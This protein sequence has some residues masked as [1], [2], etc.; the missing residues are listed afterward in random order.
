MRKLHPD[1]YSVV[2]GQFYG[3]P[4]ELWGFRSG[5]ASG[6]ARRIAWDFLATHSQL[7]GLD[8]GL[9]G[10]RWRRTITSLGAEHVIFEQV[11]EQLRIHRAY[12]T[13]HVGRS[14]RRVFLTKNRAV[15]KALLPPRPERKVTRA[16]AV[17]RALRSVGT[18]ASGA[19]VLGSEQVWCP[20]EDEL[21]L[22]W[23]IRL[24]RSRPREEWIHYVD[25]L[26]G[27]ILSEYDNLAGA[28][29]RAWVFDPNPVVTLDGT[30]EL[31]TV[32][33]NPRRR[34]PDEAFYV[35]DL[36]GLDESGHLDG[37]RATTKP[38][39]RRV[40][41]RSLDFRFDAREKGFEEVMAYYHVDRAIRY[42]ESLGFRGRSA[43]FREPLRIRA[44]GTRQDNSWYSPGLRQLTF[45]SGGVDDAEDAETILHEFGH[46]LQDAIT[47]DF[48]QSEEAAAMG[49]GF[50]DYFAA[51][52][53]SEAKSPRYRATVMSWDGVTWERDDGPPCVR[54]VDMSWTMD[55]W[56][57]GDS[58]H[59]NGEIWSST[60]WD[61][62]GALGRELADR[63]I[64]ESHFQLDPFSTMA[65]G[66]RA[67]LDADA[68]LERGRNRGTLRRIF[69]AHRVGPI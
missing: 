62:R 22:S 32:A 67:I 66:A 11:H 1:E 21:R 59:A 35:V 20:R 39:T 60:L 40:R 3:T 52:F 34:I 2:E 26:S 23:K 17:R 48:G 8:S 54:R 41:R 44:N 46:A 68:N 69:R 10:L 50:G 9:E 57:E 6:S 49:E 12:V 36:R 31:L 19:R 24:H 47:P 38:T 42:V 18:N 56:V 33:G 7:F 16:E 43:I 45:G 53:F 4:K 5:R 29:G 28:T 51:S 65:R 15:P 30:D 27:E 37:R 61:V 64:L 25:A 63:L 55:D 58:E 14:D 13:V